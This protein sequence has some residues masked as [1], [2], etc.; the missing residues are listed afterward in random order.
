M[1]S[2]GE[3]RRA[4]RNRLL[5]REELALWR[6]V[7]ADVKP[8]K[9]KEFSA[10]VASSKEGSEQLAVPMADVGA[11]PPT[12]AASAKEKDKPAVR[13][14]TPLAPL[15]KRLKRRLS[16]GRAQV[17]DVI[18]LHGLTQA[19]A[20]RALNNFLWRSAEEGAKLVLV[21][22]GKGQA[23]ADEERTAM[24]RGVLRRNTPHWLRAPE[25]RSIVLSVEEATRPH[26]GAGAL[27][28]RLRRRL[29]GR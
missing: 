2:G 16:S 3:A 28:V 21:I 25:L 14:L 8:N 24:E 29:P 6:H 4:P 7:I 26:G 17:D 19:Q 18:D 12:L 11:Q 20:H 22:T 1:K 13:A 10:A 27:Y 9:G 15:E 23:A 5:S